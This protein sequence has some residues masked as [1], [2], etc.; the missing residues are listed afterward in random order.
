[1]TTTTAA[2]TAGAKLREAM[3]GLVL[4]QETIGLPLRLV[5]CLAQVEVALCQC[6]AEAII[7]SCLELAEGREVPRRACL[8]G[9]ELQSACLGDRMW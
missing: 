8:E 3:I 9:W 4:L 6:L 5:D 7:R 1:L 2:E